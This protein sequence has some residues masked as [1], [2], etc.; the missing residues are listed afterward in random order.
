MPSLLQET[1]SALE[2]IQT[3]DV[4]TLPRRESLGLALSFADAVEPAQKAV[5]LFQQIP[6]LYLDDL[7]ERYLEE[8]KGAANS[9]YSV[10]NEILEFNPA[11]EDGSPARRTSI[12]TSL[13][14]H[15]NSIFGQ[16]FPLVSY[17]SSRERDLGSLER[18]ARAVVQSVSD[19]AERLKVEMEEYNI[20]ANSILGDIRNIAAEQGVSQQAIYFK[21]EAD[22]HELSADKW[23][24]A[25]IVSSIALILAAFSS[26]FIHKISWISPSNTYEYIQLGISKIIIFGIMAYIVILSA[27]NFLSNKHN[28]T[29][30]KHRQ[31]SLL[32]FN[33]LVG[34]SASEERRDIV[35]TYAASCIFSPQDTGYIR[36]SSNADAPAMKLI[37]ILPKVGGP[38]GSA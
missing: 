35:L 6:S 28:A 19:R 9:I 7:P 15:Y 26:L 5:R 4:Q 20:Q 21:N 31:N 10:F 16:I 37:E 23:R 22:R 12:I 29:V 3:F 17:L 27:R 13:N 36:T 8:I 33:S 32:T 1:K 18:E 30:N 24:N 38:S 14:N 34:A 11:V 25:T 2:R